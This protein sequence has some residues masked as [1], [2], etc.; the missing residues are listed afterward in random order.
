MQ[1]AGSLSYPYLEKLCESKH[2]HAFFAQSDN[3]IIGG[4]TIY[5]L[6]QYYT[7]HPLA[8]I[9][10]L[11]VRPQ[12]QRKGIGKELVTFALNYCQRHNIRG[13]FVQ[14]ELMD[15]DGVEFY[16]STHPDQELQVVQFY[17]DL[18]GSDNS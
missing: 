8:Y 7:E 11:A 14:A 6:D 18:K 1:E 2:F 17:Y 9:Y 15:E 5:V 3:L 12:F 13:A 4:L 16:R 10:D